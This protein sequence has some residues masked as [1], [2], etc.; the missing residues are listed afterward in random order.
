MWC[1]NAGTKEGRRPNGTPF[2]RMQRVFAYSI[3]LF[4]CLCPPKLPSSPKQ[5]G[6]EGRVSEGASTCASVFLFPLDHLAQRPVAAAQNS[7]TSP[8][9]IA[10]QGTCS[11]PGE[12]MRRSSAVFTTHP[13]F[14]PR[15]LMHCFNPAR[16]RG[17]IVV[18][19]L[20]STGNSWLPLR[21]NR[22]TS[23]PACVRQKNASGRTSLGTCEEVA[24][25]F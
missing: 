12:S 3:P 1:V 9:T 5:Q 18:P 25:Y 17:S 7:F 15:S 21:I 8:A 6:C 13:R 22:S 14:R 4:S 11:I 24:L 10:C 19:S 20:I 23:A 16:L 2:P